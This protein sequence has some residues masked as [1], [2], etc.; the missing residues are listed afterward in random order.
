M[1]VSQIMTRG[2]LTVPPGLPAWEAWELMRRRGIRHLVVTDQGRMVGVLS[3]ADAG[4]RSGAAVRA[5]TTV[6]HLMTPH[7]TG[8]APVERVESAARLMCAHK[9]GCLPIVDR[10]RLVGIVTLGDLLG[11]LARETASMKPRQTPRTPRRAAPVR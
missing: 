2:V 10:G 9:L 7:V 3:D 5:G 4:G 1:R 11:G 6:G 8:A